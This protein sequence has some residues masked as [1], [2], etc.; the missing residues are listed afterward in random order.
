[1]KKSS[2]HQSPSK[3]NRFFRGALVILLLLA[4]AYWYWNN[5]LRS[6]PI[7]SLAKAIAH[8]GLE[9][10]HK[11]DS[12]DAKSKGK[13]LRRLL[14][15]AKD[16]PQIKDWA[17]V[18][19]GK[20]D[21][22]N[23]SRAEAIRQYS[24]VSKNSAAFLDAQL[25]LLRLQAFDPHGG[26]GS[27]VNNLEKSIRAAHRNDLLAPL[28]LLQADEASRANDFAMAKALYLRV[29]EKFPNKTAADQ[30]RESLKQLESHAEI[31]VSPADRLHEATLLLKEKE[32]LAA[33]AMLQRAKE[34]ILEN[35]PSYFELLLTEELILRKL[36]RRSEADH[37]LA[38]IS[39]DA[40]PGVADIALLRMIKNAW[41]T[42]EHDRALTLLERF[43]QLYTRSP[44]YDEASYINARILEEKGSLYDAKQVYT[45]LA[46]RSLSPERVLQALRQIAWIH[47][48]ENSFYQA[49]LSFQKM[50]K[51]AVK[52]LAQAEKDSAG[53][54]TRSKR[55]IRT[56]INHA[57]Y[58]LANSLQR[59]APSVRERSEL[60]ALDPAQIL[61]KLREDDPLSYY[62]LLDAEPDA[63][64]QLLKVDDGCLPEIPQSLNK[65]LALLSEA[66]LP[67]LAQNEID[68][69]FQKDENKNGKWMPGTDLVRAKLYQSYANI[70][71]SVGLADLV[72]ERLS[73]EKQF[74]TASC[75]AV[76]IDLSFPTPFNSLF[77]KSAENYEI[78]P[79]L[80]YAISR[81]ESHFNPRAESGKNAQGLL[82]L[83]PST[84]KHEGWDE[85][86]SLFDPE[87]N[88]RLGA[89]HFSSL[90][91]KYNSKLPY[92][93]AAYNAGSTAVA[94]WKSRYPDLP[95]AAWSELVGYPET[96]NYIRKVLQAER[97]YRA[98]EAQ[99]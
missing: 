64:A 65:R 32:E 56:A 6:S 22:D 91:K 50:E 98:R 24:S 74:T 96:K 79:S 33:L 13:H 92:A 85:K 31:I 83:L 29:R 58:W 67:M 2:F 52:E 71:R 40:P 55:E 63:L 43:K 44:V 12:H 11:V 3:T 54:S 73:A 19:Q 20:I 90:L 76:A 28:L 42:N 48:R 97:V 5:S 14:E 77:Q 53:Q 25:G 66:N 18:C 49:A 81:T 39:A 4:A 30:A 37:L 15:R 68:W 8:C 95:P 38:F 41:N 7:E 60:T 46:S 34:E 21:E 36:S 86:L 99:R 9:E 78:K 94:R 45:D 17:L 84:A 35:T 26:N 75:S 59:I 70:P 87:E 16:D 69:Y 62:S 89:K 1:M 57:R 80:L 61:A 82:Q 51:R 23:G 72:I 27:R 10:S 88:I 47:Y 93:I